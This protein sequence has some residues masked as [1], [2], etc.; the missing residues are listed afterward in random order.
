MS[1]RLL[2]DN[3]TEIESALS[4]QSVSL[5]LVADPF[6]GTRLYHQAYGWGRLF[7]WIYRL[8]N[9]LGFSTFEQNQFR[10]ALIATH[11]LF[12]AQQEK[13]LAKVHIYRQYLQAGLCPLDEPSLA[14]LRRG[15]ANW[16]IATANSMRMMQKSHLPAVKELF[17]ASLRNHLL[18]RMR[19][20][21][22]AYYMVLLEA[23]L[24]ER[25]PLDLM[26]QLAAGLALESCLDV[27]RFKRFTKKLNKNA[28]VFGID[29]LNRAL[30]AWFELCVQDSK[31]AGL[32][33]AAL[34]VA[35]IRYNYRGSL[36]I[37]PQHIIKRGP[38]AYPK[39]I[40][41]N[42]QI[43]NIERLRYQIDHMAI[44]E[45]S[46]SVYWLAI[47]PNKAFHRI[48]QEINKKYGFGVPL[49]EY[50]EI[51]A[52]GKCALIEPLPTSLAN[53]NW[54]SVGF[55]PSN[56]EKELLR[57]VA[58]LLKWCY[59]QRVYP[60]NLSSQLLMYARDQQ[61]KTLKPCM[62][63]HFD[64]KACVDFINQMANGNLAAYSF[65]LRS[66][67]LLAH[68][69][70]RFFATVVHKRLH[71][72]A[73]AVADIAAASLITEGAIVKQAE[74]FLEQLEQF[75][76]RCCQKLQ[77]HLN[78]SCRPRPTDL[79]PI[80]AASIIACLTQLGTIGIIPP[81]FQELVM[82]HSLSR[83]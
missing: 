31:P 9:L 4:C 59:E 32:N 60:I 65:L 1:L 74:L 56:H 30:E 13:A 72:A 53:Y 20:L 2:E 55:E 49:M 35:L 3:L 33:L 67:G 62:Q 44:Y 80:V 11:Q 16:H 64:F 48:R 19:L 63:G 26:Q 24:Q 28:H 73:P 8:A 10:K 69:Y 41:C 47:G 43:Y 78:S 39:T 14:K 38:L 42:A 34:Q 54:Q 57:P 23:L 15:I 58:H 83:I 45:L 37:D 36:N 22:N 5:P 27:K 46:N 6:G 70:V 17:P 25:P 66:S 52:R 18:A 21:K 7:K 82:Q 81:H 29:R 77:A 71:Q 79:S 75:K 61:L 50:R 68:R 12:I 51:D 76:Q 40:A